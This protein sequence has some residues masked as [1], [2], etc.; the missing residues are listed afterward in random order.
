MATKQT[1]PKARSAA[2]AGPSFEGMVLVQSQVLPLSALEN[3]PIC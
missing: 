1:N 2:G 3:V